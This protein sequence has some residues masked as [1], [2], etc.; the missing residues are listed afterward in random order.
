M[1]SSLTTFLGHNR[2]GGAVL[3]VLGFAVPATCRPGRGRLQPQD[4]ESRE[5]HE[6][7]AQRGH[8]WGRR[9]SG[10]RTGSA[11]SPREETGTPYMCQTEDEPRLGKESPSWRNC[12]GGRG[13]SCERETPR[14]V[15]PSPGWG[16]T[17]PWGEGTRPGVL[18][19]AVCSSGRALLRDPCP[20]PTFQGAVLPSRLLNTSPLIPGTREGSPGSFSE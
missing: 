14:T 8:C 16:R 20:L 15:D 2:M 3:Q 6:G 17:A 18:G 11:G 1:N 10:S 7:P 12:S 19:P 4:A 9:E 13:S 5:T